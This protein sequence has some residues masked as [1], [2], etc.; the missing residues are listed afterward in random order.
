MM[1]IE[2]LGNMWWWILTL[3]SLFNVFL[4]NLN[5]FMMGRYK[6]QIDTALGF[7]SLF[8]FAL[9]FLFYGWQVTLIN[10]IGAVIFGIIVYPIAEAAAAKILKRY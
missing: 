9:I 3:I 7:F 6:L 5:P 8:I 1:N 4:I 10:F 2:F